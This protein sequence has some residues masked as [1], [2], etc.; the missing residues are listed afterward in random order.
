MARSS[1]AQCCNRIYALADYTVERTHQGLVL[2]PHVALRRHARDEGSLFERAQRRAHDRARTHQR[3][4]QARFQ[5]QTPRITGE[6]SCSSSLLFP[7]AYLAEAAI[8]VSA[9]PLANNAVYVTPCFA[10]CSFRSRTS[11]S[12]CSLC[13]TLGNS[14]VFGHVSLNHP[15]YF[16]TSLLSSWRVFIYVTPSSHRLLR[17]TL[18]F[19]YQGPIS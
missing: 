3:D 6:F 15:S 18:H 1:Q 9:R 2:R 7:F 19:G 13:E 11:R 14:A 10:I 12:K 4:R 5:T 17:R 16:S 8:G